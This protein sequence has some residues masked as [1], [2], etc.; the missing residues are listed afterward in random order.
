MNSEK[1]EAQETYEEIYDYAKDF[2]TKEFTIEN[3]REFLF[4]RQLNKAPTEYARGDTIPHVKVAMDRVKNG[5][6]V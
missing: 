3:Y 4:S 5:E 2:I 1:G 6:R